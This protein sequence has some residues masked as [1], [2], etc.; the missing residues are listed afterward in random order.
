MDLLLFCFIVWHF[1][2]VTWFIYIFS[3]ISSFLFVFLIDQG[4][5]VVYILSIVARFDCKLLFRRLFLNFCFSMFWNCIFCVG[6]ELGV[7]LTYPEPEAAS[8]GLLTCSYQVFSIGMTYALSYIYKNFS[9]LS[10]NLCL[11][12]FLLLIDV[13][14]FFIKFDLKR[15]AVDNAKNDPNFVL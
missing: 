9:E 13:F 15:S 12:A 11:V 14:L 4:L 2:L 10:G 5:M 6:Y 8:A 7:E 3:T 1:R